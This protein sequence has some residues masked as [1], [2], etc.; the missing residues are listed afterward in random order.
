MAGLRPRSWQRPFAR[1]HRRHPPGTAG[2]AAET[3]TG[4]VFGHRLAAAPGHADLHQHDA[5]RGAGTQPLSHLTRGFSGRRM[6]TQ[7]CTQA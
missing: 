7:L 2:S 4:R 1:Q 5:L 6:Q 3:P